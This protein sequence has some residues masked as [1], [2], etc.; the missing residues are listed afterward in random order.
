MP[1]ARLCYLKIITDS[2][3]RS[4]ICK[5]PKY[6][7]PVP[8]DFKSCR[9]EIAGALQEF[10]NRWCKREHV[11]SNALNSWKLNVFKLIDGRRTSD[12]LIGYLPIFQ[13]L[14]KFSLCIRYR[15]YPFE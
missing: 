8:I 3:I 9:E 10:C 14:P 15:W 12:T 11:E 6:R 2:R 4:I 13:I 1:D 5:G 7:F